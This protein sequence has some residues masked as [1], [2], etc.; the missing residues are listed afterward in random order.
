MASPHVALKSGTSRKVSPRF[1]DAH[2]LE[3]LLQKA[4]H[5]VS[6]FFIALDVV[7]LL[8]A[9]VGEI[10]IVMITDTDDATPPGTLSRP[11]QPP[12]LALTGLDVCCAAFVENA[13][14]RHMQRVHG[15]AHFWNITDC[16]RTIPVL[17]LI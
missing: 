7:R 6:V 17:Q 16:G 11:E 8:G 10:H 15:Q 2:V 4:C 13:G 14:K 3:L 1:L 12:R 5:W 9:R